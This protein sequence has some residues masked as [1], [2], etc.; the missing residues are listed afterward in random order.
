MSSFVGHSIVLGASLGQLTTPATPD[1]HV[2]D[3]PSDVSEPGLK[4]DPLL[5]STVKNNTLWTNTS[6]LK[7][8]RWEGGSWQDQF[9]T[10]NTQTE[11]RS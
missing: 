2:T 4:L 11:P 1:P 5:A 3:P 6:H 10:L 8:D 9:I 7:S